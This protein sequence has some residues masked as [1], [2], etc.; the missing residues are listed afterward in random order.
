MISLLPHSLSVSVAH[1][2]ASVYRPDSLLA[3]GGGM[4]SF[5]GYGIRSSSACR[6]C[7]LNLPPH[8]RPHLPHLHPASCGWSHPRLSPASYS[9]ETRSAFA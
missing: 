3:F 2:P 9:P 5:Y 6:R 7:D 8:F 4:K 1:T